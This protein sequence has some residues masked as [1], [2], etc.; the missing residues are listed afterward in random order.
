MKKN[1]PG[2]KSSKAR[3]RFRGF[4]N[5]C[6]L[7]VILLFLSLS[8]WGQGTIKV[9]G[10]VTDSEGQP[11]PG[12]TVVEQGTTNGTVTNGDGEYTITVPGNATL[13][14][15]FVGMKTQHVAVNSRTKIDIKLEEESIGLEEVVA[16]GYGTQSKSTMTSAVSVVK[17]EYLQ[18][19]PSIDPIQALQGKAAGL[20]IRVTDG[21]PG[22][23]ADV[24]IRGGTSTSPD[25]DG[26]LYVIDGVIRNNMS[27]PV[28]K[29]R[30]IHLCEPGIIRSP[31]GKQ[32]AVLLR[33]NSRRMNSHI[34]FSND[35][36]KSWS[37]PRQLPNALT[38]D[39]HQAIY[40]PDGR[41]VI[42]FRDNSP[43][44]AR[45]NRMKDECKN[46]NEEMLYK[47]AGAVSPTAGDWVAWVGTYND[48]VE[49]NEGQ[50][51]IRFKDNTKGMDCCYPALELLPDETIVATT[52]GHWD[53][54]EEPYILSVRFKMEEIDKLAKQKNNKR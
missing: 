1:E 47:N 45:F 22:A 7:F 30:V 21:M 15:S 3:L 32:I 20:D 12:A 41:L 44:I 5:S 40:T 54:G 24:I 4:S 50:Y 36:G 51:R 49:V 28:F 10:T 34:I 33:E 52:Y 53:E 8:V 2:L 35:E 11:L 6:T 14:F 48:L 38:G 19:T 42:S 37:V 46:C 26:P 13:I 39:R 9:T 31:D 17:A 29:S 27:D 23:S 25:N 43:G 16:I 18:N